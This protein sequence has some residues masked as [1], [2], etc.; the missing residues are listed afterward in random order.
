MNVEFL[1]TI[2][3]SKFCLRVEVYFNKNDLSKSNMV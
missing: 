2:S 1:K 3:N